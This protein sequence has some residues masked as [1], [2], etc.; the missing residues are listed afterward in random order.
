V[1]G[2]LLLFRKALT[3]SRHKYPLAHV[4]RLLNAHGSNLQIGY[5]IGCKFSSSASRS[6]LI[7]DLVKSRNTRFCVGSFHG[8][9]HERGCQLRWHPLY[10]DGTGLED[11]E[12]LEQVFSQSNAVARCT[13]H[14]SRFHRQQLIN[15]YFEAWNAEKYSDSCEYHYSSAV[16]QRLNDFGSPFYTE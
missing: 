12:M 6:G 10:I 5:D 15:L 3:A 7:G 8:H 11:F 16:I 2:S 9:A 13:R 14:T 4:R 1:S